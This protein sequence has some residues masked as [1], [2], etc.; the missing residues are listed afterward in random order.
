M[1]KGMS[2]GPA[3]TKTNRL[4]CCAPGSNSLVT[5]RLMA[6]VTAKKS[7]IGHYN[8]VPLVLLPFHGFPTR[9]RKR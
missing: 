6:F 5:P 9:G 8:L 3:Q 1:P 4:G 7:E 2:P